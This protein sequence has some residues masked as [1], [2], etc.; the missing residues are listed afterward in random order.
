MRKLFRPFPPALTSFLLARGKPES[1]QDSVKP[2]E[3]EKTKKIFPEINTP[4]CCPCAGTYPRTRTD[5]RT[6][7]THQGLAL[8]SA[9]SLQTLGQHPCF[10]SPAGAGGSGL[11]PCR[12]AGQHQ[13]CTT[14]T[15]PHPQPR[16]QPSAIYSISHRACPL[17]FAEK[18]QPFLEVGELFAAGA[19]H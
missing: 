10:W 17:N 14:A 5:P 9:P 2:R 3:G 11:V 4:V 19:A 12:R 1:R 8:C 7:P 6:L 16:R 18:P 15:L 13:R